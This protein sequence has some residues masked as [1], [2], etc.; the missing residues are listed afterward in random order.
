MQIS[1]HR[2]RKVSSP[3]GT[4]V[5]HEHGPVL[6]QEST[7]PCASEIKE[8]GHCR[9]TGLSIRSTSR[10]AGGILAGQL[11]APGGVHLGW[12]FREGK[13]VISTNWPG[14]LERLGSNAENWQ[15]RLQKPAGG[16]LLG[17]FFVASRARLR[18]VAR[19][20]GVRDPA[21]LGG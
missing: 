6:S 3:S 13:A 20:L 1:L 19:R 12:F 2:D 21:N 14:S 18:E 7:G 9:L 11:P 16:R 5:C 15:V 4:R 17:R 8:S 10:D